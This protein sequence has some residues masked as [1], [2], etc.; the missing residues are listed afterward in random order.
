M[1]VRCDAVEAYD[2]GYLWRTCRANV[3]CSDSGVVT[4]DQP[5]I[6]GAPLPKGLLCI[7]ADMLQ[8]PPA[9]RLQLPIHVP[10]ASLPRRVYRPIL[11]WP[12]FFFFAR[13]DRSEYKTGRN[14]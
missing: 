11:S 2:G 3:L 6:P 7:A 5:P 13:K 10:N 12:R 4:S 8:S 14:V 1:L 9:Q